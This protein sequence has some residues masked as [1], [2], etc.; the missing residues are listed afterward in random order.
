MVTSENRPMLILFGSN[1]RERTRMKGLSKAMFLCGP[2]VW[3]ELKN[4]WQIHLSYL[5]SLL[6]DDDN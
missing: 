2:M 3:T 6:R 5:T 4:D 1:L